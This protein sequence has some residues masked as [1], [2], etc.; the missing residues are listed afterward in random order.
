MTHRKE[1]RRRT[2]AAIVEAAF[3]LPVCLLFLFGILEYGRFVMTLQVMENAAREGARY[4]V[5]HTN[6]AD[7]AAV[8]ARVDEKMA[9]T[10]G[11]ITA[12]AVTVSGIILQPKAGETAGDALPDW[13]TAS[14]TDGIT[15]EVTGSFQ[16]ALPSFLQLGAFP[17]R[18]KAVM[19]SEGN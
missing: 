1:A 7:T 19:Y 15:V 17:L 9:G 18:A 16:P 2:A 6:D 10:Q 5:A 11:A 14:T 4:A 8:Q 3:V 13:T 12:Y